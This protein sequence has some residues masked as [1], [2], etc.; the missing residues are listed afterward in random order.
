M[1]PTPKSRMACSILLLSW[2]TCARLFR[3]RRG[4]RVRCGSVQNPREVCA[5]AR[6]R[7]PRDRA[8]VLRRRVSPI[9]ALAGRGGL[10]TDAGR[11][12][13]A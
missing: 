2:R 11:H 12:S 13:V 3:G 1:I 7:R 9:A 10:Q 5:T 4:G 8:T 6:T